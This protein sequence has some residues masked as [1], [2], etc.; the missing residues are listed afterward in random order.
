MS[1]DTG[2]GTGVFF[3]MEE[4]DVLTHLKL[5][6]I[7]VQVESPACLSR[8]EQAVFRLRWAPHLIAA[9]LHKTPTDAMILTTYDID[10][11]GSRPDCEAT[12]PDLWTVVRMLRHSFAL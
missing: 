1:T 12:A 7:I 11:A 3:S 5:P 10:E 2:H 4:L 8:E 9:T 6:G